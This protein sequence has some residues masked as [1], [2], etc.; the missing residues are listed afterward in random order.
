MEAPSMSMTLAPSLTPL[1]H[2]PSP[3]LEVPPARSLEE[4]RA[5]APEFREWF[6]ATGQ[7]DLFAARSL[8]TLP[9]PKRFGLWEACRVPVPYVWMTNRM[10]VIQWDEDGRTRTLVAEPSDYELGIDTPFLMKTIQH[11]PMSRER[12][13]DAFF[14]RH[15]HVDETLATL[16]IQPEDVDFV[17]FDH[18]HT[19]DIRRLVGTV[20]PAPDLGFAD[21]PVP[22]MFPNAKLIVERAE[23]EHVKEVHPFQARFHQSWTYGNIREENLEIIDGDV[24]VAPGIALLRT[25]G[26]TLGN[27]TLVV[28]TGRGIFTSSENGIAVESYAPEHSKLPGVAKWAREWGYEVVMNFNTPEYASWQYNSMI[29]EKLIADPIPGHPELR[30][31]FPSSELTRHRLAPAIRPLFE[32]GDLTVGIPTARG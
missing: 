25:P 6:R 13:L 14:I 19:Q 15:S 29:K 7:V 28:N 31:V 17:T 30:Q 23:L 3:D 16:G 26:H 24:L 9:Y 4:I 10:F 21:E 11:L 22:P 27:H 5:A 2:F 12:A 1:E 8:V 18:L 20:E 32:H